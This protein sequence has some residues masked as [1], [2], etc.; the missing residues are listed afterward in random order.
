MRVCALL[1]WKLVLHKQDKKI[2]PANVSN[3]EFSAAGAGSKHTEDEQV[4]PAP[5]PCLEVLSNSRETTTQ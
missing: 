2:F 1:L 3:E 4:L 5:S